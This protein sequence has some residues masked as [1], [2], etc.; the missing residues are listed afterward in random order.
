MVKEDINVVPAIEEH[1]DNNESDSDVKCVMKGNKNGKKLEMFPDISTQFLVKSYQTKQKSN[2][3]SLE[4]VK[5]SINQQSSS[6]RH[7]DECLPEFDEE[8]D[9]KTNPES[10]FCINIYNLLSA[11]ESLV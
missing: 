2:Y 6:R 9:S 7:D 3:D 10:E 8:I 5:F 4:N 1:S 11:K